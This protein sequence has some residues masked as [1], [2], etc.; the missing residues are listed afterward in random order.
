MKKGD[1]TVPGRDRT[2]RS[3][4]LVIAAAAVLIAAVDRSQALPRIRRYVGLTALP[5]PLDL[6]SVPQPGTYDSPA[7]LAMHLAANC[8]HGGVVI[9]TTQFQS[10]EG[11]A[12]PPGR[13][14]VKLP[15]TEQFV[16]MTQPVPVTAPAGPGIQDFQLTFRVVTEPTDP[17]GTYTGTLHFLTQGADGAPAVPG[18][19]VPVTL[20]LQLH[21]SYELVGGKCYFHLGNVFTATEA[22][23]TV[24]PTGALATNAGMFI[25]LNV[26]GMSNITAGSFE[27]GGGHLTGRIFDAMVGTI[28]VLGRD[29]SNERIDMSILLSWDGGGSFAAPQYFGDSP[30]GNVHRTMW[31]L[32]NGGAPGI[33][34]LVWEVKLLPDSAHADGNYYFESEVVVAPLL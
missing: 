24:R 26:S 33:Y 34:S 8:N 10:A 32:V 9:S 30:D 23:L 12:I 1:G 4:C 5:S 6:G 3:A 13:I 18:P 28:D 14:L 19:P 22:D 21:T 2:L 20:E 15:G 7:T 25:G 29:I 11:G 16:A 27:G 31:W 17:A